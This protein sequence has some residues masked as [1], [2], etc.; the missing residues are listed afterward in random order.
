MLSKALEKANNAVLFHHAHVFGG[1]VAAYKEACGLLLQVSDLVQDSD[2]RV[3]LA[4]IR[5]TYLSRIKEILE[6]S[7]TPIA[8]SPT[9]GTHDTLERASS[10][11]R[12]Q[13][14]LP[15]E[16]VSPQRTSAVELDPTDDRI[17]DFAA[18][19]TF[20]PLNLHR[21][22]GCE[23]MD[24]SDCRSATPLPVQCFETIDSHDFG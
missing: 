18:T 7:T 11:H 1:A 14:S 24:K 4:A 15:L 12:Q 13:R 8:D 3:K 23:V 21:T 16:H 5:D 22:G 2:D 6:E 20:A 17:E 9:L 19:L 10:L